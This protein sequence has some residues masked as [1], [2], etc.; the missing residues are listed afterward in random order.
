MQLTLLER[1]YKLLLEFT[2]FISCPVLLSYI[3]P[4]KCLLRRWS[5]KSPEN[6]E[7]VPEERNTVWFSGGARSLQEV[8]RTLANP[9]QRTPIGITVHRI[10]NVRGRCAVHSFCTCLSPVCWGSSSLGLSPW[11]QQHC[12]LCSLQCLETSGTTAQHQ[13]TASIWSDLECE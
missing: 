2:R 10:L 13:S 9:L 3:E 1:F 12:C 4:Q 8:L 7:R 11:I 6:D 5:Q